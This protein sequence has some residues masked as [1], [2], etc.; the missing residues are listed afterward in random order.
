M[1]KFCCT[2][3]GCGKLEE[4]QT[5]VIL[6]NEIIDIDEECEELETSLNEIHDAYTDRF[7]CSNCGFVIKK[8]GGERVT[9]V[10]ELI[11]WLKTKEKC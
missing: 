7:Q 8:D 4:I 10:G 5:G 1:T 3:C 11:E 2:S 9:D 6:S